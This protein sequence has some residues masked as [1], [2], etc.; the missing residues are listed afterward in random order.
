MLK[1][2]KLNGKPEIFHSIQGEGKSMG[3]PSVFIRLSLCNLYCIWCDTDH[4]WNW[5]GTRYPHVK[6]KDP[7]YRKFDKSASIIMAT[8]EEIME[9]L[10]SYPCFNII[11]T[12]GEPLVQ[13]KDLLHLVT[14]MKRAEDTYRFEVETNGTLL[15]SPELDGY[16]DQYNVSVKLRNSEVTEGERLKDRAIAYFVGNGK[17]SFKFVIDGQGDL[18]EVLSLSNTYGISPERVYLMPQGMVS[19]E[20]LSKQEWLVEACKSHG[21]NYTDRLH[22]HIYGDKRGV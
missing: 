3:K 6:D 16:I 17:A 9:L 18:E 21:F 8:T 11:L 7:Q 15:P 14:M 4:T 5:E 22:I 20:L 10:S 2:A 12:G 13:Q 19:E 1:L